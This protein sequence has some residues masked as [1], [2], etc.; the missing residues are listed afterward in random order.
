MTIG[1][2]LLGFGRIGKI[3]YQNILNSSRYNRF[4]LSYIV[5]RHSELEKI[6]NELQDSYFSKEIKVIHEFDLVLKDPNIK[7]V[8]ICTPTHMHFSNIMDCLNHGKHVFCEKPIDESLENI[9]ICYD[10]AKE[11]KLHLFCAFN[12]RFDN[13]IAELKTNIN[14]IGNINQI[15]SIT[16][17]YP[18]PNVNFLKTSSG[19]FND[20]A[21][22]DIDYL[23]WILED[24]PISVYVSAKC[25]KPEEFSAN[26]LDDSCIVMEYNNG[27]CAFIYCSRISKTYDQRIEIFGED[28]NL[29]VK[30][31]YGPLEVFSEYGRNISFTNR[32]EESYKNELDYFYNLVNGTEGEFITKEECLNNLCVVKACERSFETKKKVLVEYAF[33]VRDYSNVSIAVKDNYLKGRKYQTVDYVKRMH[34]KYL[35]FDMCLSLEDI[36]EKLN[37]FIDVSDPDVELPNMVHLYESAEACRKDGQPEWLQFITLIHDIGKIMYIKGNDEDGTSVKEQWG[38]VGDTFLVGCKIPESI[39][40]PEYNKENP[41]MKNPI[42][43]S[44]NGIYEK[45]C[46]IENTLCSWGHDE[47]LYHILLYNKIKLPPEAFYIVRYHSLYLYHEKNEYKHLM[48]EKDH[49]YKS[50]LKNFNK[51]DLYSKPESKGIISE[52][53]KNYYNILVKK[54]IPDGK[55][56]I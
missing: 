19:L 3:H 8:I 7:C 30:N 49:N 48:N 9:R 51:Y 12:R 39:I 18:Y 25:S 1:C 24:K 2:S 29:T 38:I 16:R 14:C 45:N 5:E 43:S 55:I 10:T 46:G 32:Y 23:N 28:G 13:K 44:D 41:D 50:I 40:F 36:F 31:P 26:K 47:Y 27:I 4:K 15:I 54:F 21:L 42:Y 17:D 11:K 37:S 53:I 34:E 56:K 6:N 35:K 33:K 22:H 52:D 20:C